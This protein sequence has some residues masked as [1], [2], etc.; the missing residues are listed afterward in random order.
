M[1]LTDNEKAVTVS[2]VAGVPVRNQH[3]VDFACH[4]GIT[5]LTCQPADPAFKGEVESSVKVA[6]A[7]I[8]PKDT[9]LLPEYATFAEVEAAC[10]AFMDHVNGREHRATPSQARGDACRRAGPAALRSG[11]RA[12]GR[13]RP[14]P[15]A[16]G[17]HPDGHVRERPILRS[18]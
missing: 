12:H 9:N 4:Y 16:S 3:T 10:D 8:V 13:V 14:V 11:H 6:K 18:H 17:E 1:V 2:H 5:M 7:D 15:D